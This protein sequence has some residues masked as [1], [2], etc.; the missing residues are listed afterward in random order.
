MHFYLYK[1]VE[2]PC[3]NNLIISIY[4]SIISYFS[5]VTRQKGLQDNFL[6]KKEEQRGV[7]EVIGEK[8]PFPLSTAIFARDIIHNTK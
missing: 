8:I 4:L 3:K 6:P 2:K 5:F 7:L 1:I